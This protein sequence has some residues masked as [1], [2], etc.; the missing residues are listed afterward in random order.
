MSPTTYHSDLSDAEWSILFPLLPVATTGCHG[1]L[2][3][4]HVCNAI[5]YTLRSGC[6]WRLLPSDFPKWQSV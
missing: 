2:D 1:S 6:T 4:H 3:L 5:F